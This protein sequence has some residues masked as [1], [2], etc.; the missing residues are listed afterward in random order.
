MVEGEHVARLEALAIGAATQLDVEPLARPVRHA[1]VDDG[2]GGRVGA[3]VHHEDLEARAR[4][5]KVAAR[6]DDAGHHRR[7]VVDGALNTDARRRAHGSGTAATTAVVAILL[8]DPAVVLPAPLGRSLG[9]QLEVHPG[10][11]HEELLH[12]GERSDQRGERDQYLEREHNAGPR[13]GR[14]GAARRRRRRAAP[15][16]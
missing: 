16:V 14:S 5:T 4:V 6:I 12:R 1:L 3:V 10:V 2:N 7:I 13:R 11:E 8:G 15:R 9:V